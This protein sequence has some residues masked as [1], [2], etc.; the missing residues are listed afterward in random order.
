MMTILRNLKGCCFS[1]SFWLT[2]FLLSW[3]CNAQR[4]TICSLFMVTSFFNINLKASGPTGTT[5]TNIASNTGAILTIVQSMSYISCN[6]SQT[7]VLNPWVY[8]GSPN[9]INSGLPIT[10]SL[11]YETTIQTTVFTQNFPAITLETLLPT[12]EIWNV[13]PLQIG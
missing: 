13:R 3:L 12:V 2:I 7:V 5:T 6:L 4:I 8:V 1:R 11:P 9:G 10:F